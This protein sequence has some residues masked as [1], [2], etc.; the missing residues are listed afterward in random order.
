MWISFRGWKI[1][2][3]FAF[4][5]HESETKVISM[6][7]QSWKVSWKKIYFILVLIFLNARCKCNYPVEL[8]P[9]VE[10]SSTRLPRQAKVGKLA[11]TGSPSLTS[12]L[13]GESWIL[14]Y[15]E[16]L[17]SGIQFLKKQ[18]ALNIKWISITKQSHNMDLEC[19]ADSLFYSFM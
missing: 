10:S 9:P 6:I 4:C 17:S 12:F 13:R 2:I 14:Q 3:A 15:L 5:F 11:N 18:K 7:R 8:L 1:T 19:D 16:F